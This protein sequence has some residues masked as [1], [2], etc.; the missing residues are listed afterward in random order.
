MSTVTSFLLKIQTN[1]YLFTK[2]GFQRRHFLVISEIFLF[3]SVVL[4]TP[5]ES[6]CRVA[7]IL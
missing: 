5:T 4:G 7:M 6:F 3:V 1:L 2:A